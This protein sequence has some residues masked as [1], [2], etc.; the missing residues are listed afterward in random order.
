MAYG[1]VVVRA[2]FG[3][4]REPQGGRGRAQEDRLRHS[5]LRPGVRHLRE[6]VAVVGELESRDCHLLHGAQGAGRRHSE[7]GGRGHL[8]TGDDL[9]G[10]GGVAS[11]LARRRGEPGV[12]VRSGARA[13]HRGHGHVGVGER[14]WLSRPVEPARESIQG[15]GEAGGREPRRSHRHRN[16]PLRGCERYLQGWIPLLRLLLLQGH[17]RRIRP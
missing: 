2:A 5:L 1:D 11:A 13:R 8:P 16:L 9:A 17:R 10:I 12:Q 7:R 3:G 6:Y 15:P 4:R 14:Q